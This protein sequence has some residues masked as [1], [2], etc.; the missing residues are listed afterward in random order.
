MKRHTILPRVWGWFLKFRF[1][2]FLSRF[3]HTLF[4]NQWRKYDLFCSRSWAWCCIRNFEKCFPSTYKQK[5]SLV[6]LP[7]DGTG[8]S[9]SSQFRR[10][11]DRHAFYSKSIGWIIK[12][13]YFCRWGGWILQ[14]CRHISPNP[15]AYNETFDRVASQIP[16]TRGGEVLKFILFWFILLHGIAYFF[17]TLHVMWRKMN[18]LTLYFFISNFKKI[19]QNGTKLNNLDFIFTPLAKSCVFCDFLCFLMIFLDFVCPGHVFSTK[20]VIFL[21]K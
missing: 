21:P 18:I 15:R 4:L 13:R 14:L 6:H 9:E 10:W 17:K 19:S 20:F 12:P 1:F 8:D 5:L 11:K 3:E 2:W 16:P 7:P